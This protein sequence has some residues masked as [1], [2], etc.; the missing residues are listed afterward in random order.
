[1]DQS[2]HIVRACEA[3]HAHRGLDMHGIKGYAAALDIKA[4]GIDSTTGPEE[5]C[6]D[7]SIVMDISCRGFRPRI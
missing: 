2:F 7:R 1:M 3:G 4:G 5:C 6:G